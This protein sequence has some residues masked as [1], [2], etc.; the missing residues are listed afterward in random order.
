MCCLQHYKSRINKSS[1]VKPNHSYQ[2]YIF[3]CDVRNVHSNDVWNILLRKKKN[4]NATKKLHMILLFVCSIQCHFFVYSFVK[5][6]VQTKTLKM[7]TIWKYF[8]HIPCYE[9][10]RKAGTKLNVTI[11]GICLASI[12]VVDETTWL[13]P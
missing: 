13:Q 1:L 6:Y 12:C 10:R 2:I 8:F 5:M 9:Y 4:S 11:F 7:I 3:L